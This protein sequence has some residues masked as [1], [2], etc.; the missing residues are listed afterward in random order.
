MEDTDLAAYQSDIDG[1]PT[2]TTIVSGASQNVFKHV[3][4]SQRKAGAMFYTKIYLGIKNTDN[5]ALIT[6]AVNQFA[7]TAGNL[8][9]VLVWPSAYATAKND[10]AL[11][12]ELT[13]T[14]CHGSAV[15]SATVVADSQTIDVTLRDARLQ[16]GGTWPIFRA[17]MTIRITNYPTATSTTGTEDDLTIDTV[18]ATD[19]LTCRITTVET[20]PNAYPAGAKVQ[21]LISLGETMAPSVT[22]P[23]LSGVTWDFNALP[24]TLDNTGTILDTFTGTFSDSINFIVSGDNYGSCG[25]GNITTAFA[26]TNSNVSRPLFTLA[27]NSITA[28]SAGSTFTFTTTPAKAPVGELL[29]IPANTASLTNNSSTLVFSGESAG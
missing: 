29:V 21:G 15:T 27:A 24:L 10:T 13:S 26:P 12:P 9:F 7:P 14:N 1:R 16:P 23:V 19:T 5:G 11:A 28:A 8:E 17:G 18:T 2:D 20:I 3:T 25:A 22:D 6:P 4:S